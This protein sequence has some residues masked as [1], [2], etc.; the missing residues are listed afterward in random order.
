MNEKAEGLLLLIALVGVVAGAYTLAWRG[1]SPTVRRAGSWVVAVI[2]A[3]AGLWG[4]WAYAI[5]ILLEGLHDPA[6][7]RWVAGIVG[8]II[9]ALCVLPWSIAV[10]F[11][12]AALRKGAPPQVSAPPS[13]G[14]S[15]STKA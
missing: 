8:L 3:V 13:P 14:A 4:L 1:K 9:A 10:R 12:K 2:F 11:V 15:P 5:P 6:A 7:P